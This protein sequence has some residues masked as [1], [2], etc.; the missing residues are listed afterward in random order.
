MDDSEPVKPTGGSGKQNKTHT[1]KHQE[2]SEL[3]LVTSEASMPLRASAKQSRMNAVESALARGA[4]FD[5]DAATRSFSGI[6]AHPKS[7]LAGPPTSPPTVTLP[8]TSR[9]IEPV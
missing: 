3:N 5:T 1:R 7:S 2:V 9:P 8:T 6:P 4:K